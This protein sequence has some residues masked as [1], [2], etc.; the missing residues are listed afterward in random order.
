MK[1]N[2]L[3]SNEMWNGRR[4]IAHTGH[5]VLL[6]QDGTEQAYIVFLHSSTL[7]AFVG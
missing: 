4:L 3:Y 7:A 1:K 5:R 2:V 6:R